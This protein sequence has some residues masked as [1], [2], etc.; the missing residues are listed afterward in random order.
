MSVYPRGSEWRRWDLHVHTPG[1]QKNDQYDGTN[2]NQKWDNFYQQISDYMGDG[3]DPRRSIAVIGITD[4][5]STDNYFKVLKENR[6]PAS[7]KMILPNVELRMLPMSKCMPVNIHCIFSPKYNLNELN[8][9]FFSK[10]QFTYKNS[11]FGATYDELIRLGRKIQNDS[12]LEEKKAYKMGIDQYVLNVDIFEKIFEEDHDL[13]ENTIV[14]VSNSSNDGASGITSH[15]DYFAGNGSQLDA[16]RQRVY[17]LADLIFSSND[18]DIDYFLGKGVDSELEIKQ[19]CGS[20]M[21]CIHGSDA[22]CKEKLFEPSKQKYCWIKSDPTFNGLKQIVYE[23]DTRICISPLFPEVKPAYQVI[24]FVKIQNT[25]V[26]DMPIKF[27][28]HLTCII[29]GKSTGKSLLLH[30]LASAIDLEQVYEKAEAEASHLDITERTLE[31]VEV[32]WRDGSVSSQNKPDGHKIVYIPQTYLNRLSDQNEEFTEIDQIIS[33]IVLINSEAKTAFDS[34]QSELKMQK[35]TIDRLIYDVIQTYNIFMQK[36]ADQA[37]IGTADGL[38]DGLKKLQDQKDQL[39]KVSSVSE[40]EIKQYD[41]GI[42]LSNQHKDNL[43]RIEKEID[44]IG[45]LKSI[46]SIIDFDCVLS[47]HTKV[48]FNK[49]INEVKNSADNTWIICQKNILS[50]LNNEK[51]NF[52]L[53]KKKQDDTIAKLTPKIEENEAIKK[54]SDIVQ[55]EEN[56]VTAFE[57]IQEEIDQL[58][59]KCS[60]TLTELIKSFMRYKEIHKK[61]ESAINS[62]ENINTDDLEFLVETPFRRETFIS[63][64]EEIFDRRSLRSNR[65]IID[66]DKIDNAWYSEE[67][68]KQFVNICLNGKLK[69][70]KHKTVENALREILVDWYNS[71]YKVKMDGDLIDRMSPGKKALVLLKLLINLAE[72]KCPILIDQPED[73]LDNRSIFDELIPFIKKKKVQRQIIIV[74][75]NANVVLGGD[76][77]EVIVANQNGQNT[78]NKKFLFEYRS[79]AIE[80]DRKL[81]GENNVLGAHGIQQQICDILEGGKEAF[82][83]RKHKYH[84]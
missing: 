75:H 71:T 58:S 10:L 17:Q 41:E 45:S 63:T 72:S 6:L 78:P 64:I 79:G 34:M 82:D 74:T 21:G 23:P 83:L 24:D 68:L 18:K 47:E 69:I 84:I 46:I 52:L 30:N 25:K 43:F 59:K 22:H 60:A 37:E 44:S 27:N 29:G 40:I 50:T 80:E 7:V 53:E 13:R 9:R 31:N 36:K 61:Y 4:Y 20:I 77:E 26:Q 28:D 65:E 12:N 39:T 73:D 56:K 48:L 19:K 38:N 16:T 67:N 76:A 5:L 32:H 8:S 42:R 51:E 70:A 14:V 49:A 54:L 81:D 55:Q 33:D 11:I 15:S 57:K 3:S 2:I 62:N 66:L 35:S 1:T